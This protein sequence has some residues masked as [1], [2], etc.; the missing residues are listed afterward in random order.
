MGAKVHFLIEK[1]PN[2]Q[3]NLY[4]CIGKCSFNGQQ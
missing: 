3:K 1:G 2:K 4:L